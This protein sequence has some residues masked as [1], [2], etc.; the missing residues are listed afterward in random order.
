MIKNGNCLHPWNQTL[1]FSGS[2]KTYENHLWICILGIGAGWWPWLMTLVDDPG[3]SAIPRIFPH[4]Y[5]LA[6][7]CSVGF[8]LVGDF[9]GPTENQQSQHPSDSLG[10]LLRFKA[11]GASQTLPPEKL[12]WALKIDQLLGTVNPTVVNVKVVHNHGSFPSNLYT[13]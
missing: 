12:L 11:S 10:S 7:G 3:K 6:Q 4:G 9:E 2:M 1:S 13:W 5:Q 8:P